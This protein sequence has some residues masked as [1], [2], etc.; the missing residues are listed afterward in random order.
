MLSRANPTRSGVVD[1][2]DIARPVSRL[3]A[4]SRRYRRHPAFARHDHAAEPSGMFS[5]AEVTRSGWSA[6]LCTLIRTESTRLPSVSLGDVHAGVGH[7]PSR[8]PAGDARNGER[9]AFTGPHVEAG[10]RTRTGDPL[11][12]R[13]A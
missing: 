5:P 1:S 13:Q 10:D 12:T 7:R 2:S 11:F 3:T 8:A 9:P 6:W 4:R